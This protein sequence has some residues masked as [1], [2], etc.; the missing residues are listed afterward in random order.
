MVHGA[1]FPIEP[2]PRP[3]RQPGRALAAESSCLIVASAVWRVTQYS[4]LARGELHYHFLAMTAD[5]VLARSNQFAM[6]IG[7]VGTTAALVR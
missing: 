3:R 6:E 7:P 2:P 4:A 1:K 5:L